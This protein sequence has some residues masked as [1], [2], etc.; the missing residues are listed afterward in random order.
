MSFSGQ[1]GWF[2]PTMPFDYNSGMFSTWQ[3]DNYEEFGNAPS[4]YAYRNQ[5]PYVNVF[6]TE[7][8]FGLEA[9]LPGFDEK[10]VE[11]LLRDNVLT[12]RG[13]RK[14]YDQTFG[15]A[16]YYVHERSFGT[17]TR[18]IT[19]PFDFDS[20]SMKVTFARGILTITWPISAAMKGKSIKLP[21]HH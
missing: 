4:H 7:K 9:E 18:S 17:F 10:D 21:V 15:N 20:S 5:F 19:L 1:T 2:R 16:H 14:E 3:R 8:Y 11:V 12:I 6:E 13:Q